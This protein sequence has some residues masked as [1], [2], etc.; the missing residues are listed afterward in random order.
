MR[1]SQP[2]S[3]PPEP[4]HRAA[5]TPV[6]HGIRFTELAG[7]T[8][9]AHHMPLAIRFTG[10]L[11]P[12]ALAD[13][14]D[15]LVARHPV[16]GSALREADGELWLVP[17]DTMPRLVTEELAATAPERRADAIAELI[18]RETLRPFDPAT[19]PP[20]RFTL[21]DAGP[22]HRVLL[23]VVHHLAFDGTSKDILVR[24]LGA[25]YTAFDTGTK[26]APPDAP[27]HEEGAEAERIAREAADF[28]RRVTLAKER[29]A[30][31]A[32]DPP[33]VLLPG[34]GRAETH[35]GPGESVP[36]PVD[37]NL[38]RDLAGTAALL[39]IS[40][41]A[42]LLGALHVLLWRY[43]NEHPTVAVGLGTRTPH[44]R[45]RI[46][47]YVNELP[48]HTHPSPKTPFGAFGQALRADLRELYRVRDVPLSRAVAGLTPRLAPAPVS[49]SY[50][51]RTEVPEF[52][53]VPA[54]IDWTMFNHAVRGDLHLQCLDDPDRLALHLHFA[55]DAL[56][57]G[58][59]EAIAGHY[60]TLLRAIVA[61]PDTALSRLAVLTDRERATILLDWNDTTRAG[62]PATLPELFA[63]QVARTPN[64]PAVH[65]GAERLSYAHLDAAVEAV[66]ERLRAAGV[67]SGDLVAV[68]VRRTAA[69]PT[70]LLG[71]LRSGAGYLPLD[72]EY[73]PARLASVLG[74]CAAT[75]L[76]T[77]RDLLGRFPAHVADALL[78]DEIGT[79]TAGTARRWTPP[80]PGALAYVLATSGST[81]RPKGVEIEHGALSNLL[82]SMRDTLESDQDAV[83]LGLTSASF[84]ISAVELYLPLITGG[85][86]VLA[87]DGE[88]RDGRAL[89]RLIRDEHVSHVQAT[90]SGWRML[91]D[92]GFAEPAVV[93]VT[94]GEALPVPLARE[95]RGRTARLVNA[96]GPTETTVWSGTAEIGPDDDEVTIGRP[97]AN[98]RMYILDAEAVP[99]P[100]GVEGDLYIA[101]SGLARGYRNL[102]GV[103]ADRFGPDPF[104][105]PGA[106][107]Y[108]TGDRARYRADGRIE[109]LGRVDHQVKI[110]GHRIEPG[111]IEAALL[112]HPDIATAAVVARQDGADGPHLVAYLVPR[113][114]AAP[115]PAELRVHLAATLPRALVPS[116]FVALERLPLTPNGKLDRAA[117]PAP[118]RVRVADPAPD[119]AGRPTDDPGPV[120]EITAIWREVLG[121]DDIRPDEDLFDL[122]GHSLTVTRIGARI[123]KRLGVDVPLH[124]FFES[125]TITGLTS[126]VSAMRSERRP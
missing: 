57:R 6:Q 111:E 12:G 10:D 106:R 109:Y 97:I 117:L 122:G 22:G 24:E 61:A 81:G 91:L 56:D 108:R 87:Q 71:I 113:A 104:G 7:H 30:A 34:R 40:S 93:A 36:I 4:H 80:M 100:I 125:P 5:V 55:T 121:L 118:P 64:A 115:S 16:L 78:I 70:A 74:D 45:D 18:R 98:T 65:C 25:L 67:G 1:K 105:P 83:W 63:A 102:P 35:G 96:Y 120:A 84:D 75:V 28:T 49:M 31:E 59:A 54:S 90:P 41:F 88:V 26:P 38:R 126:A 110:L 123:R 116:A 86:L 60:S 79:T 19:G 77:E 33:P 3:L 21:L 23:V 95:L 69:L 13:A 68:C 2:V 50:R 48:V 43:G 62:D 11:D 44:T 89:L 17:A 32:L 119:P 112:E 114:G 14:C 66:A 51:R 107:M 39:G 99:V 15:A 76:L 72:P 42:L 52:A 47:P 103:T 73:P 27:D 20:A 94:G 82:A 37:H 9:T 92:A 53:G 8:G 46:G 29:F 58:T 85:L 124:V 101:G